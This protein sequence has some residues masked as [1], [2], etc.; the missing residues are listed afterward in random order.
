M[1]KKPFATLSLLTAFVAGPIFAEGPL[2]ATIP[3][4]FTVGGTRM[5]AGE[6]TIALDKPGTAWI[7]REDRRASCGV[8][9]MGVSARQMPESGK[10]VFHNYRGTFFLS[11]IW[12][13]GNTYGREL[14]KSKL[15]LEV[16]RNAGAAQ[17]ASVRVAPR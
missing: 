13:P 15:E 7:I 17:L 2:K 3:F 8:V 6:Y 11:Q 14:H 9:T 16:A 12:S 4:D 10:L 5:T 1:S